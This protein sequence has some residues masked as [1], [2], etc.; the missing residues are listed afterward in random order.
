MLINWAYLRKGWTSCK[1]AQEFLD[2][3]NLEI[4]ETVDARKERIADEKAWEILSQ[5][6]DI[7]IAKGKK[8]LHFT[9]SDTTRSE[10]LKAAMG[11]S[12]NLRA[13][14]L[15][16]GNNFLVGFKPE[17]YQSTLID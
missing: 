7:T 6:T 8:E 12:G 5:A 4:T 9:P 1:K 14:T 15:K 3:H 10:I 16:I 2:K 17:L 11:P 13:P